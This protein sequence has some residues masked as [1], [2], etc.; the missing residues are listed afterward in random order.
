MCVCGVTESFVVDLV[1]RI[2]AFNGAPADKVGHSGR[3]GDVENGIALAAEGNARMF[4]RQISGAPE[5]CGDSLFLLAIA[6]D[7]DQYDEGGQVLVHRSQSVR[8]PRTKARP[9]GHLV[10]SL[11][12]GDRRFVIDRFGVQAA[13]PANLV[14]LL[15][16]ARQQFGI[17]PHAALPAWLNLNVDGAIGN[18]AWPLVIVVSR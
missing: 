13:H 6:R 14:G 2:Q 1:Q 16:R 12:G 4:A 9:T 3:V 5:P 7:R 8:C 15:R 11:H 18:L 17:H 10:A